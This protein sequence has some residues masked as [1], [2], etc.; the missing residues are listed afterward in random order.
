[1]E[2]NEAPSGAVEPTPILEARLGRLCYHFKDRP[3]A[4]LVGCRGDEPS[5]EQL[6][7]ELHAR[8]YGYIRSVATC[9][10]AASGDTREE[11]GFAVVGL[12]FDE[13][14]ELCREHGRK[15][16]LWSDGKGGGG[17]WDVETGESVD[18]AP[19]KR[20]SVIAD[21]REVEGA[22]LPTSATRERRDS[23]LVSD[24]V[25]VRPASINLEEILEDETDRDPAYFLTTRKKS[26]VGFHFGSHKYEEVEL[27]LEAL[28][29]VEVDMPIRFRAML[30]LPKVSIGVLGEDGFYWWIRDDGSVSCIN[31]SPELVQRWAPLYVAPG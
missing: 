5:N 2:K 21:P 4:V 12:P 19:W 29:L 31:P 30:G 10:D 15:W 25:E 8:G 16:L 18:R 14:M 26:G 3:F 1:M 11:P 6:A 24:S 23:A 9:A 22:T 20:L 28:C 27:P 7:K 13:A 17:V